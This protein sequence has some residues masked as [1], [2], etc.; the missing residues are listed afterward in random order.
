MYL[1]NPATRETKKVDR[2]RYLQD[3]GQVN[4]LYGFGFNDDDYKVVN[5]EIYVTDHVNLVTVFNVYSLRTSSWRRIDK[6]FPYNEPKSTFAILLNGGQ[7]WLM[8]KL[9][10]K[11]LVIASFLLAEENVPEIQLPVGH[12]IRDSKMVLGVFRGNKL[13]IADRRYRTNE[14][15]VMMEYGVRKSWTKISV[16][17]PHCSL[18]RFCSWNN[19]QDLYVDGKS[20][21]MYNCNSN[22]EE[23]FKNIIGGID[24]IGSVGM[25]FESLVSL[26]SQGGDVILHVP[27]PHVEAASHIDTSLDENHGGSS[28]D[29]G[30]GDDS[31]EDGSGSDSDSASASYDTDN[32]LEPN[33]QLNISFLISGVYQIYVMYFLYAVRMPR[34]P[35]QCRIETNDE[36]ASQ[37]LVPD[38]CSSFNT[39][40]VMPQA[41]NAHPQRYL[42]LFARIVPSFLVI[43]CIGE[44]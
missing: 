18:S 2:V 35:R 20:L 19:S 32:M 39:S 5:G 30:D 28:R 38:I 37:N 31:D 41:V 25:Y 14:I 24:K 3:Y 9:G 1:L 12:G 43:V 27:T 17:I 36:D 34:M 44:P 4:Y 11:S 21:A 22:D 10:D 26:N 8:S 40:F 16:Y 42:Q 33:A 23:R 7:H 13:F 29:G 15:W 6:L